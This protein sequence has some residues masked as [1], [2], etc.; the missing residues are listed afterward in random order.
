MDIQQLL[1]QHWCVPLWKWVFQISAFSKLWNVLSFCSLLSPLAANH[2][3]NGVCWRYEPGLF[4]SRLLQTASGLP[5]FHL[6]H[7]QKCRQC[8]SEYVKTVHEAGEKHVFTMQ[9]TWEMFASHLQ[10]TLKD[11]SR[12]TRP[13][14]A[15]TAHPIRGARKGTTRGRVK[16][17]LTR[18]VGTLR[19]S[20]SMWRRSTSPRIQHTWRRE[21]SAAGYLTLRPTSMSLDPKP[22][23]LPGVQR[24]PS[25][26]EIHP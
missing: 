2:S 5:P 25:S 4:N 1:V 12:I 10:A 21:W 16:T 24:S 15:H 3:V 17:S 11:P 20:Q 9:Q 18:S 19:A 6:Q 8:G 14:S 13:S 7:G 26:L 23:T 22:R